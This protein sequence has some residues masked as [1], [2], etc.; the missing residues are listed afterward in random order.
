MRLVQRSLNLSPYIAMLLGMFLTIAVQ[1]SSIITS[2]FT[3]LV[4]LSILT[5]EQMYPLTLGSNIGTTCTAILASL[6]TESSNAIQIAI[7][8]FIFNIM[9]IMIWFPIPITR[10][11]PLKMAHRLGNLVSRYRWF[12]I[13]YI[14]YL[15][16]LIPGVSWGISNLIS[17]NTIG[18]VFGIIL[19]LIVC[20]LT[21][22]LFSRFEKVV[23]LFSNCCLYQRIHQRQSEQN[24]IEMTG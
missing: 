12:G 4:G 19:L 17:L 10:K 7:C 3:P 1:S 23:N 14:L 21:L 6:V 13:F 24:A 16:V 11:V 2:T 18:L 20:I 8:H 5:V 9:G 22:L 15:F